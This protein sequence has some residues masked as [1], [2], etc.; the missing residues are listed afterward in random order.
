[1]KKTYTV[2]YTSYERYKG[3]K[4]REAKF[5]ALSGRNNMATITR[6]SDQVVIAKVT[7]YYAYT[8]KTRTNPFG[9]TLAWKIVVTPEAD[10][11]WSENRVLFFDTY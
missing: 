5:K 3:L 1:M 11:T 9:R 4:L 2:K 6:E 8:G 10:L 7:S